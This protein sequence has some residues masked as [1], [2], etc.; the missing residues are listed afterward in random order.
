MAVT[1]KV[2]KEKRMLQGEPN[3]TEVLELIKTA[4]TLKRQVSLVRGIPT[5]KKEEE[6]IQKVLSDLKDQ[7]SI[8]KV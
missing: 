4:R 1:V 3:L 5:T 6:I 2:T 7:F 8:F